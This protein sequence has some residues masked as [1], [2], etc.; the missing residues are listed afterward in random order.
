MIWG[1]TELWCII[2]LGSIPP[3]R[4]LFAKLFFKAKN[5]TAYGSTSRTN[6]GYGNGTGAQGYGRGTRKSIIKSTGTVEESN[7]QRGLASVLATGNGSQEEVLPMKEG[8]GGI[9][10]H[11]TFEI[12]ATKM[13][14]EMSVL[15]QG[16]ARG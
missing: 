6:D 11:S 16:R 7:K 15:E 9:V 13:E 14:D 12:V 10:V 5:M 8:L 2:I 4:P 3:L 1:G